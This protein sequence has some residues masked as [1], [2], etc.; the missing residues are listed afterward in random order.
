MQAAGADCWHVTNVR[1]LQ[2]VGYTRLQVCSSMMVT[3]ISM[4]ALHLYRN[5]YTYGYTLTSTV[6][7]RRI[8]QGPSYSCGL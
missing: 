1:H 2:M 7:G 6:H 3:P 4:A 5:V 8:F